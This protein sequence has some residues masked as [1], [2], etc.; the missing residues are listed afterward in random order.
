MNRPFARRRSVANEFLAFLTQ[1]ARSTADNR[2]IRPGSRSHRIGVDPAYRRSSVCKKIPERP[3]TG[4]RGGRIPA[5]DA[6]VCIR[7]RPTL[8]E[9]SVRNSFR[10][11]TACCPGHLS[12]HMPRQVA[13]TSRT[14]TMGKWRI[15]DA[16]IFGRRL[17]SQ[18]GCRQT[19]AGRNWHTV[20]DR[21]NPCGGSRH[22]E[23]ETK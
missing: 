13:G 7:R 17:N 12:S 4:R 21:G 11:G 20:G 2:H 14:M 10:H 18:A 5:I 19:D 6:F 9:S 15:Q 8:S 1:A 22:L 3:D 16:V 23:V